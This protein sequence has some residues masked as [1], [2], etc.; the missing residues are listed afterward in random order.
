MSVCIYIHI[1][2]YIYTDL[3]N[4]NTLEKDL[5]FFR[6]DFLTLH[7]HRALVQ[8]KLICMFVFFVLG[9]IPVLSLPPEY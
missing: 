5:F 9:D 2:I 4:I 8:K 7:A 1:Y 3:N 6:Q